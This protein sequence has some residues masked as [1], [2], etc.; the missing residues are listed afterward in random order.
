MP[1]TAT[2]DYLQ[3]FLSDYVPNTAGY[4]FYQS[5]LAQYN[6]TDAVHED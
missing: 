2:A 4:V 3:F 1:I 6:V 5:G